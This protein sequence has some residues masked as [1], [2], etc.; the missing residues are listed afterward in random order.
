MSRISPMKRRMRKITSYPLRNEKSRASEQF[1]LLPFSNSSA[2]NVFLSLHE[3]HIVVSLLPFK[4]SIPSSIQFKWLSKTRTSNVVLPKKVLQPDFGANGNGP[5]KSCRMYLLVPLSIPSRHNADMKII[6]KILL[7][8]HLHQLKP[9][10]NLVAKVPGTVS[11]VSPV[12]L[13]QPVSKVTT[14]DLIPCLSR[15]L[16]QRAENTVTVERETLVNRVQVPCAKVLPSQISR[17]LLVNVESCYQIV[18]TVY[19]PMNT[20]VRLHR[21]RNTD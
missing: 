6:P 15:L 9:H 3:P 17:K 12:C 11:L 18:R 21:R 8:F 14:L 16:R 1:I 4:M 13:V 2:N 5:K 7:E 19:E 10:E 20:S